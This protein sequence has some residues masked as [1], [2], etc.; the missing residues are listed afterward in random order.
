MIARV[1]TICAARILNSNRSPMTPA[2]LL[3]AWSNHEGELRGYLRHRMGNAQD[4]EDLLQE[5]FLKALRQGARFCAVHNARAWLFQVARNALADRLRVAHEQIPL[6]DELPTP[7]TEA[8]PRVDDL[9]QCLPRVLAELSETDRLAIT[10]CDI[11]GRSQQALAEQLGISLPGAKSR[12]QRAR[13]R[14][15]RHLVE[16]CQVRFDDDGKVCCLTPRTDNS[17]P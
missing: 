7:D 5:V 6:P 1:D 10:L 16:A 4:A 17:V 3:T 9:A 14:L 12:I 13:T 8:P 15:Q 11:E 2:C